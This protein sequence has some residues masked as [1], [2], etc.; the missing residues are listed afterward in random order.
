MT[1]S[2]ASSIPFEARMSEISRPSRG[3]WDRVSQP[4][5]VQCLPHSL[6]RAALLMSFK[7]VDAQETNR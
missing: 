1:R 6:G 4:L 2:S 3:T 5:H 7:A